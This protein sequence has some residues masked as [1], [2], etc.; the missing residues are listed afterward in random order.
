MKLEIENWAENNLTE[1][2]LIMMK[3]AINCF[4]INAYRSAFTMSYIAFKL[5]I[6]DRLISSSL[7]PK[8]IDNDDWKKI[9]EELNK[10][11]EWENCLNKM[12]DITP[13]NTKSCYGKVFKF[14]NR[15]RVKS[16]YNSW[17]YTRHSCAHG[18]SEIVDHSTVQ[19]FWNYMIIEL[20]EFYI[21]GGKEYLTN[22]ILD[23]FKF[24]NIG[25]QDE[26]K[27]ILKDIS[28][29]FG[30]NIEEIF[31]KIVEPKITYREIYEKKDFWKE[32][33]SFEKEDIS[34]SF[35]K[36]L[37]KHKK[38]KIIYYYGNFDDIFFK[39]HNIDR[40]FFQKLIK[41]KLEANH[42]AFSGDYSSFWRFIKD[43]LHTDIPK[44][45]FEVFT[46]DYNYFSLIRELALND[47]DKN[48]LR[49]AGIFNDFLLKSGSYL[50]KN[51]PEDHRNQF[52]WGKSDD[53][54][55]L[56]CKE[57]KWDEEIIRKFNDSYNDLM[58]SI[59]CRSNVISV[60]NGERRKK[61][62]VIL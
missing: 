62:F 45:T 6:K 29:V 60:M 12:I 13:D 40:N 53:L 34:V 39:I 17:K 19:Q 42:S 9:I 51:E 26:L 55:K 31:D 52:S 20:P 49:N 11:D 30:N 54:L 48:I 3:E 47:A 43:L 50:F 24:W 36:Y 4:K 41:E 23:I 10:D 32:I 46:R 15:E 44:E 8:N 38:E 25:R 21:L 56:V 33:L 22:E 35:L 18:R 2:A 16:R 7:V 57:I 37:I 59:S 27:N 5:T 61:H 28:I 14:S 1:N 58:R